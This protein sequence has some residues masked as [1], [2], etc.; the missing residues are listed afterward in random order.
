M[1]ERPGP[2]P[3]AGCLATLRPAP[4]LPVPPG[5]VACR[6]LL[7][8]DGPGRDLVA[9]LKY[10]NAR[11]ALPWVAAGMAALAATAGDD[12]DVVTWAPTTPRRRRARG[13]DQAELLARR[14]ARELHRPA[15]PL[16]RREPGPH[17]TGLHLADRR[18]GPRF[19]PRPV[20][21]RAVPGRRVL[22]VDD[23]VTSG[24][25]FS[26]AARALTDAGAAGVVGLA[27]A[28]TAPP[29]SRPP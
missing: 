24:A 23:V 5:L 27:A 3:C 7:A 18:T 11:S 26:R 4:S 21:A 14:V 8:Y 29:R 28:R 20:A 25:T 1:C 15:V 6:A 22:L 19:R 2:A 16:L 13:F 10:R 17:Q 9:R 12:V